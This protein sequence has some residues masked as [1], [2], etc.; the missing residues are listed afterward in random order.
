MFRLNV[1]IKLGIR[2]TPRHFSV[3]INVPSCAENS[4]EL[5]H[6]HVNMECSYSKL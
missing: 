5:K 2:N 3:D 4:A 1:I 6:C